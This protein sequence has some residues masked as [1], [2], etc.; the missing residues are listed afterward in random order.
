MSWLRQHSGRWGGQPQGSLDEQQN[1]EL[2]EF[3]EALV[4][5]TVLNSKPFQSGLPWMFGL[6][7]R[8][9]RW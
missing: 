9:N 6:L 4:G 5:A 2:G 1:I 3:G 7:G 8:R